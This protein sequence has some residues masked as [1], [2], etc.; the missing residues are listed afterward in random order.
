M[1]GAPAGRLPVH[2]LRGRKVHAYHRTSARACHQGLLGVKVCCVKSISE[3]GEDQIQFP[4]ESPPSSLHLPSRFW[5]HALVLSGNLPPPMFPPE[6]LVPSS[7]L[8]LSAPLAL[9]TRLP[10]GR[11]TVTCMFCLLSFCDSVLISS[12]ISLNGC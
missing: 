4:P 12:L 10:G 1:L 2:H 11:A 5:P 6:F 3:P 7:S 8:V 9:R